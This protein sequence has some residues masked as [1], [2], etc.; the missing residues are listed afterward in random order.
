MSGGS[1]NY[2]HSRIAME[3][4]FRT[5]TVERRAFYSHMQK[6]IKAL[7]DSEW[8][9]SGDYGAGGENAAIKACL[10]NTEVMGEVRT[11]L[12]RAIDDAE[13]VLNTLQEENK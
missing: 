8:V 5:D 2:L 9:D 6:V 13:R 1:M 7:H 3:M 11:S 4:S 12:E 10:G